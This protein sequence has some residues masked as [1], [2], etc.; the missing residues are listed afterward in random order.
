MSL[1][2]SGCLL[3]IMTP[4]P[5]HR[6]LFHLCSNGCSPRAEQKNRGTGQ[7]KIL[8]EVREFAE[9]HVPIRFVPE[10]VQVERHRKDDAEEQ[11][12]SQHRV[13]IE[14]DRHATTD[15]HHKCEYGDHAGEVRVC[16]RGALSDPET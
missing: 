15:H 14:K 3:L 16:G 6:W 7:R 8:N 11:N 1:A 10:A 9:T 2:K 4:Y 5:G 12:G 13:P